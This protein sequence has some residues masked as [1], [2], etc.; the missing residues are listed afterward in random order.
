MALEQSLL[1]EDQKWLISERMH[2]ER[3]ITEAKECIKAL[4]E[5]QLMER[6]MMNGALADAKTS[7]KVLRE[8]LESVEEN[9]ERLGRENA[10]LEAE[11]HR[12]TEAL[13]SLS[14]NEDSVCG[15]NQASLLRPWRQSL[16]PVWDCPTCTFQNPADNLTC[17]MCR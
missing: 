1:E 11:V 3:E 5:Q 2:Q 15:G 4:K 16:A 10:I 9:Q 17:D 7:N 13:K 6:E 14:K 8:K 12:L